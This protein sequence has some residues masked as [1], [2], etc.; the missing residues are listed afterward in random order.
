MS[1][2]S[3]QLAAQNAFVLEHLATA[4]R[5]AERYVYLSP[6]RWYL[7]DELIS[8]AHLALVQCARDIFASGKRLE[9]PRAY[10]ATA[11]TRAIRDV[12]DSAGIGPPSRT[13][14][15]LRARIN[16]LKAAGKTT[17]E[18]DDALATEFDGKQLRCV[19]LPANEFGEQDSEF[20][21]GSEDFSDMRIDEEISACCKNEIDKTIIRL[22]LAGYRD[23]EIAEMLNTSRQNIQSRRGAIRERFIM[24]SA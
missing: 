21:G 11:I 6:M 15:R 12:S 10:V 5:A 14:R 17:K 13:R 20:F 16:Q 18:I 1:V 4:T 7:L 22:R 9:S 19:P 23:G 24:R 8:A 3:A 2:E